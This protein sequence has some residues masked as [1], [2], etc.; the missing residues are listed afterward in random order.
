MKKLLFIILI[1]F[2]GNAMA[3]TLPNCPSDYSENWDNCIG[4][5]TWADGTKYVGEYK[6]NARTG[7]GTITW[8]TGAK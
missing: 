2:A 7:Q 4:T 5:F 1:L 3:S 6:A 8:A